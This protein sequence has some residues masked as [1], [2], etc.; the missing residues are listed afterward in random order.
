LNEFGDQRWEQEEAEWI[1][2][3]FLK[4]DAFFE[5]R[6]VV[7]PKPEPVAEAISSVRGFW[8]N[9]KRAFGVGA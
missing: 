2:G 4:P 9:L 3:D 1:R 7:M 5:H 6:I 8:S